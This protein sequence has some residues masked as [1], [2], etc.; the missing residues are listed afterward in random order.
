MRNQLTK[1]S[2]ATETATICAEATQERSLKTVS[3][4]ARTAGHKTKK[5][6][7]SSN[8]PGTIYYLDY[9]INS[10]CRSRNDFQKADRPGE[11]PFAKGFSPGTPFPK[12]LKWLRSGHEPATGSLTRTRPEEAYL[13][14]LC[15]GTGGFF[16]AIA[17]K[18]PPDFL[19]SKRNNPLFFR[20]DRL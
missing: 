1:A 10:A 20:W 7:K 8:F 3:A 6:P 4:C 5:P 13:G 14:V 12:T 18:N 16:L 9:C 19:R 11:N 2:P 17:R 15:G